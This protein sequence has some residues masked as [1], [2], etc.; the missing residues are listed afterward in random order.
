MANMFALI[1][2]LAT[3]VTGIIWCFERFKWA[4]ARRA[5][6]AAVNE[7]TAGA[8]DDKTL[9]KVAKQPGWVETGRSE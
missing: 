4:P 1:L 9:A 8:V 2:A 7:Q 3:L 6:I 5:K